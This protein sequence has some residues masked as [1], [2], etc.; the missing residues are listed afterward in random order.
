MPLLGLL[1]TILGMIT[2]FNLLGDTSPAERVQKL[3][4][5]IGQALYTTAAGLSVSIPFVMLHHYLIGRLPTEGIV[6]LLGKG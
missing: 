4:P 2:T 1:G 3:A 5:G 6:G